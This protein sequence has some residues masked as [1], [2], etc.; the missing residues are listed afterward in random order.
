MAFIFADYLHKHRVPWEVLT[1]K[2]MFHTTI[3]REQCLPSERVKCHFLA[4]V[5]TNIKKVIPYIAEK[6][7]GFKT[8]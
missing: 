8:P 3:G 4:F 2:V 5:E 7:K 1:Y 6:R